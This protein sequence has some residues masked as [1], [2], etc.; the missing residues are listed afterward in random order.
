MV[1]FVSLKGAMLCQINLEQA[2]LSTSYGFII[3]PENNRMKKARFS[4]SGLAG[5]LV[6]Y[7]IVVE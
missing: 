1:V 4:L 2:D 6:K 5:L 7:G 3:D